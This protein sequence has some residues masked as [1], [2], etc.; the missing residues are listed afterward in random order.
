MT[1]GAA[2]GT[3]LPFER[4][5]TLSSVFSLFRLPPSSANGNNLH[6]KP[7]RYIGR[8]RR[9]RTLLPIRMKGVDRWGQA[10]KH[11]CIGFSA[12]VGNDCLLILDVSDGC[13]VSSDARVSID[14]CL[15][16]PNFR[17]VRAEW[18]W[19]WI[20]RISLNL[21][22]KSSSYDWVAIDPCS[23]LLNLSKIDKNGLQKSFE[24]EGRCERWRRW[25]WKKSSMSTGPSITV[26]AKIPIT[27]CHRD[28]SR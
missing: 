25:M 22:G 9:Y 8:F 4:W 27:I 18:E 19:S 17:E 28:K 15:N 3:R 6:R 16:I 5:R 20:R 2:Q 12:I 14:P 23:M 26:L 21:E 24:I 1:Y 13:V 11:R 10:T 7:A